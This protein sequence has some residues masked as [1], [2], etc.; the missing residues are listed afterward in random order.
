MQTVRKPFWNI[1]VDKSINIYPADASVNR[2]CGGN[3]A[4]QHDSAVSLAGKYL[5]AST[6]MERRRK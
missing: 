3:K 4:S 5:F 6:R 2:T 1:L